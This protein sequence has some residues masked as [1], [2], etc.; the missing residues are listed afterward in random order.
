VLDIR[1][2]SICLDEVFSHGGHNCA[3]CKPLVRRHCHPRTT[4]DDFEFDFIGRTKEKKNEREKG[5]KTSELF[6]WICL[7]HPLQ[8]C[9][10]VF[11]L[12]LELK[13]FKVSGLRGRLWKH[14]R[15]LKRG[16]REGG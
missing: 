2:T 9:T 16:W 13:F 3:L 7:W 10:T 1:L 6:K 14:G 15:L 11:S 12:N 8:M 4:V 5:E